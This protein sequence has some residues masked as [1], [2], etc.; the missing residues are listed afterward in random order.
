MK[1][2]GRQGRTR[3]GRGKRCSVTRAGEP[4]RWRPVGAS[5]LRYAILPSP[6]YPAIFPPLPS[7]SPP[8]PSS[9]PPYS[10]PQHPPP[11]PPLFPFPPFGRQNPYTPPPH[12]QQILVIS[13]PITRKPMGRPPRT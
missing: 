5:R 8:L 3:T 7:S 6:S 11:P 10:P 9:P 1:W 4:A 12:Y 2:I 13:H